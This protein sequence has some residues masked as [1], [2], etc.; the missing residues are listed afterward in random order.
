MFFSI[1]NLIIFLSILYI[2]APK[3]RD[4]HEEYDDC[5]CPHGVQERQGMR[6]DTVWMAVCAVAITGAAY[7][8]KMVVEAVANFAQQV[9]QQTVQFVDRFGSVVLGVIVS[10]LL[11]LYL[12]DRIF[13]WIKFGRVPGAVKMFL[14]IRKAIR[15]HYYRKDL[16]KRFAERPELSEKTYDD[17]MEDMNDGHHEGRP[18]M[19]KEELAI[20]L[21]QFYIVKDEQRDKERT[22]RYHAGAVSHRQADKAKVSRCYPERYGACDSHC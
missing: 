1:F 13:Y 2:P 10:V 14:R 17:I 18:P 8:V 3:I 9:G 20:Y 11:S 22:T 6:I 21:E 16:R 12:I 15:T 19:T 7:A 5:Y 4:M